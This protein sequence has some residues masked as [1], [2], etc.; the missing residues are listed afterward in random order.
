MRAKL[1]GCVR[2]VSPNAGG[3]NGK[4]SGSGVGFGF[5]LFVNPY[6]GFKAFVMFSDDSLKG[7][8]KGI[9]PL[10]FWQPFQGL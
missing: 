1:C 7:F 3:S 6:K 9:L 8:K 2:E 5:S 10:L 4:K